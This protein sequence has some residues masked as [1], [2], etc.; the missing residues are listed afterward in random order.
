MIKKKKE[1]IYRFRSPSF[2]RKWNPKHS[3]SR[4]KIRRKMQTR[5]CASFKW[6]RKKK[7][8]SKTKIRVCIFPAIS[9]AR[10]W[11]FETAAAVY[12][13]TKS[14]SVS[15]VSISPMID[16]IA[17]IRGTHKRPGFVSALQALAAQQILF[18]GLPFVCCAIHVPASSLFQFTTTPRVF[19]SSDTYVCV[20]VLRY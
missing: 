8:V 18:F 12:I 6:K 14:R 3:L 19:I 13:D 11:K 20:C 4:A 1:P 2:P 5:C 17:T 7:R 15:F 10:G 9:R 16:S